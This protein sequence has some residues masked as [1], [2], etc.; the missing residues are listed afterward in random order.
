MLSCPGLHRHRAH[1]LLH[2]C[3]LALLQARASYSQ[4]HAAP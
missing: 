1:T 4:D 2:H 3:L